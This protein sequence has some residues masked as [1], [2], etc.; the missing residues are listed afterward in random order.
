[1]PAFPTHRIGAV[2]LLLSSVVCA[3]A[4]AH[5]AGPYPSPRPGPWSVDVTLVQLSPNRPTSAPVEGSPQKDDEE[6]DL[7]EETPLAVV[8][9][10]AVLGGALGAALAFASTP[11]KD[12]GGRPVETDLDGVWQVAVQTA[13]LGAAVGGFICFIQR[14]GDDGETRDEGATGSTR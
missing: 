9:L 14:S 2:L 8:A 6:G 7:C 4:P 5:A 13:L 3:C 11:D 1:M 12:F 10:G